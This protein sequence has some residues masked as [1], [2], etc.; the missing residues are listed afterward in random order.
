MSSNTVELGAAGTP[1]TAEASAGFLVEGMTCANC[2]GRVERALKKLPGVSTARVNLATSRADVR[3][4]S[5]QVDE[6]KLFQTVRNEGYSPVSLAA[7]A[8]GGMPVQEDGSGAGRGPGPGKPGLSSEEREM[9]AL[10]NDLTFSLIFGIPLLMLSMIPMAMPPLMDAMMRL[11]PSHGF[12][13]LIQMLLATPVMF[14]PGRRFFRRG[15]NA[16]RHGSPD[17]N[18]LVMLGTGAAY[19]SSALATLVPT[20]FPLGARDVYFEAAAVVVALVL[21][22]KYLEARARSRG[23][24]AIGRLLGLKPARARL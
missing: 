1:D 20:L 17:M 3:F 10:R 13:N 22:G 9:A 12:W 19:A 18:T 15:W 11:N 7:D 8:K 4:D 21:L 2:V 24:Q 14:G 23:A 16:L 5:A 6:S